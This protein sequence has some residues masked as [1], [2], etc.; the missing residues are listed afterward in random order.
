M[1]AFSCKIDFDEL[2]GQFSGR[3]SALRKSSTLV[4]PASAPG[5]N[6]HPIPFLEKCR[7]YDVPDRMKAAGM[8]PFFRRLESA[9]DPE[10]KFDGKTL[11]M[12]GSNN[13]L[14]LTS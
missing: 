14:G 3:R 1:G 2:T 7:Q 4:K 10:V 6:G 9:Q 11:I 8:F 5:A 13:Y 12:L